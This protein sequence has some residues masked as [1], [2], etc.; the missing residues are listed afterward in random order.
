MTQFAFIADWWSDQTLSLQIF[1]GFGLFAFVLIVLQAALGVFAGHHGD[2][3]PASDVSTDHDVTSYLSLKSIAA[4]LLGLGFGGVIAI[5][6][7]YSIPIAAAFG[8]VIG[9]IIA[10]S[11][12]LLMKFVYSLRS[13]GTAIL[14]EAIGHNGTVYMRIPAENSG[15]GEIQVS[16]SGRRQNIKAYTT[17]PELATG[18]D[19]KVTALRGEFALLVE[20]LS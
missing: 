8:L 19:V 9:L 18:T 6:H 17:G 13:D 11:Y 10:A 20:K 15:A 12:V 2:I 1:W 4:L 5:Q 7:G 3:G 14:K 16:F